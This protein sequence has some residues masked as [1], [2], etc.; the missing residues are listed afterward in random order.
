MGPNDWTAED[1]AQYE[2]EAAAAFA[3]APFDFKVKW[4]AD[5]LE[6]WPN[7][8]EATAMLNTEPPQVLLAVQDELAQRKTHVAE[9]ARSIAALF[10]CYF[11]FNKSVP[12]A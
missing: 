4:Y 1:E 9:D 5:T 10:A 2:A 6:K 7:D 8:S 12:T 3:H 11:A